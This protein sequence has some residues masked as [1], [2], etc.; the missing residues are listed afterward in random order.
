[1]SEPQDPQTPSREGLSRRRLLVGAAAAGG[2]VV[3]AVAGAGAASA[4]GGH[5]STPVAGGD[6]VDL[7]QRHRFYGSAEQ[8]GI[9]TPQQRYSVFM[10]FQLTSELRTDLQVLLA[11]WSASIAQLMAGQTI[12]QVE[13]DRVDGIGDDTGEA[14]D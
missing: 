9:R 3:G 13:P 6:V 8:A 12:G 11:R 1:M 7:A 5:T 10:T 14:L 4:M 2:G